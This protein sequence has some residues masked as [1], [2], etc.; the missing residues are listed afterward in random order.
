MSSSVSISVDDSEGGRASH[1][2]RNSESR[3]GAPEFLVGLVFALD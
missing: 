2:A 1:D 3:Y